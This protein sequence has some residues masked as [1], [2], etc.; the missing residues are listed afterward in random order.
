VFSSRKN[1]SAV[2]RPTISSLPHFDAR[3]MPLAGKP[4]SLLLSKSE[5]GG[6]HCSK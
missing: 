6:V 3:P 5:A 4:T 1:L 2:S